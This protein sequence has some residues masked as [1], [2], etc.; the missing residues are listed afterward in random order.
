MGK[1]N[2]AM[3]KWFERHFIL[4][5]E[6]KLLIGGILLILICGLCVKYTHHS[7]PA[8]PDRDKIDFPVQKP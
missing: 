8:L 3:N 6:E 7:K 4:T 1:G 2:V 5:R